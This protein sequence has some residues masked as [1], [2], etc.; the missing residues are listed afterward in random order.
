MK[1]LIIGLFLLTNLNIVL[2]QSGQ[3]DLSFNNTGKV[4]TQFENQDIFTHAV[5]IQQDGKILVAGTATP[6]SNQSDYAVIRYYPD[7]KL[8]SS[9]N[10]TGK[11]LIDFFGK[12]DECF[13]IAV[14]TDGKILLTGRI[15]KQNFER[16]IGLV[17]LNDDGSL[18][19]TFGTKG[20]AINEADNNG[21]TSQ[22]V[23]VL[24]DDKIILTGAINTKYYNTCAVFKYKANG[25]L[26]S[27]FG[28]N[29][30]ATVTVPET[31]SS[32]FGVVQPDGKIITGGLTG[33]LNYT[34]ILMVRF[35]PVGI[36][37]SSFGIDGIVETD[38]LEQD[39]SPYRIA[40]QADKKIL[41]VDGVTNVEGRDF[42]LVR[43]NEDGKLDKTFGNNGI[44]VTDF[45][46]TSN[47]AHSLVIQQDQKILL[48]GFLGVTPKHDFAIAR[49][50]TDG[51]LDTEFGTSGKLVTDF[52]NDDLAFDMAI[53]KDNKIVVAGLSIDNS[54]L[55]RFAVSRYL[56]GLEGVSTKEPNFEIKILTVY[57]NPTI[58]GA[59]LEY[60]LTKNKMLNI[61]LCD[62][63]GELI[64]CFVQNEERREG[65]N[66]E[67]LNLYSGLKPGNYVVVL[68]DKISKIGIN[69]CIQN[70]KK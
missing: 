18:D 35:N 43:Y 47:T 1:Y 28:N 38:F 20:I 13:G 25:S 3:L 60:T 42:G 41:L 69:L 36:V 23:F 2:P 49:Y 24:D 62:L 44:V 5:V 29:G 66:R 59:T 39:E 52:G 67:F 51:S 48:S 54:L 50:N 12:S 33:T 40:L 32:S 4:I 57:P 9:F 14:Q 8:D 58:T 27:L 6:S 7:G 31:Y 65:K 15:Y 30:I 55:G 10:K 45:L 19:D 34:H 61:S 56:S 17:R 70:P 53:Q 22:N 64:Q 46:L 11:L 16:K 26:D 37:D 63:S 68:D 21:E